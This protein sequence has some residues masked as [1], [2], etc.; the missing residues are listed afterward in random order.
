[1]E[2]IISFIKKPALSIIRELSDDLSIRNGKYGTYIFYKSKTMK[3]PQF[4]K[5]NG[6][7]LEE[8]EDYESCD[9]ER[10]ITWI[11]EQYSI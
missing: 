9:F 4:L 10:L 3:K 8:G 1:M 5:L 2:D 7:R 11:S 6:F